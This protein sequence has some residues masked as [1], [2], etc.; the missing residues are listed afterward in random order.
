QQDRGLDE[1]AR[2]AEGVL[3][4]QRVP[5]QPL[6]IREA[7]HPGAPRPVRRT[8]RQA[9]DGARREGL[10]PIGE[11]ARG[12]IAAE[13]AVAFAQ[14]PKGVLVEAHPD[15]KPVLLDPAGGAASGSALAA[16]A[17]P[18]LVERDVI[19]PLVL[20]PRQLEGRRHAGA[21]AADDRHLDGSPKAHLVSKEPERRAAARYIGRRLDSCARRAVNGSWM[22]RGAV[23]WRC[24]SI[25]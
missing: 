2:H 8:I 24:A 23:N 1:V 25:A 19:L 5:G 6:P 10:A 12:G 9:D 16:E 4:R 17:P 13:L 14:Q 20:G 3:L 18:E 21:A 15:V 7:C 22:L 11:A